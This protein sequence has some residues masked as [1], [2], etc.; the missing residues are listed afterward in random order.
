MIL[1]NA[2]ELA[3]AY[4]TTKNAEK[5]HDIV[6][7]I[8]TA[9]YF[10]L[11]KFGIIFNDEDVR[12]D[13]LL[14]FYAK[15]PRVLETYDHLKANFLTYLI[16]SLKFF[17]ISFHYE[18]KTAETAKKI[19]EAEERQQLYCR[20]E[21]GEYGNFNLYTGDVFAPY[22]TCAPPSINCKKMKP[23]HKTIFLLACKSC[24]FLTDA[25]I[26]AIAKKLNIPYEAFGKLIDD[27]RNGCRGRLKNINEQIYKRN[28][29]Y[30]RMKLCK[31]ILETGDKKTSSYKKYEKAYRYYLQSWERAIR[32]NKKQIKAPSNRLIGRYVNISRGTIDKNIAKALKKWYSQTDENIFSVGE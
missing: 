4:K 26:F 6:M 29:Y 15:I 31:K 28:K 27:I 12:N 2:G 11:E 16:Q 20:E 21:E 10:N 9:L 14:R 24:L 30:M 25:M 8:F 18:A 13:F 5:R 19:L 32:L 7:E 17:R 22:K 23:E 3:A 1:Q